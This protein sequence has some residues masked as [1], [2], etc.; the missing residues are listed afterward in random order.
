MLLTTV[1]G[2]FCFLWEELEGHG[3]EEFSPGVPDCF[4]VF[5][6]GMKAFGERILQ[7]R[8]GLETYPKSRI[9]TKPS[10]GLIFFVFFSRYRG[11]CLFV[12][13]TESVYFLKRTV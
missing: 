1:N 9:R 13:K 7:I 10:T 3:E 12:G 11:E 6:G 2:L 8:R 4:V 5:F